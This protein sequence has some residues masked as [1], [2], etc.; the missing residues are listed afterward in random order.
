VKALLI[1]ALCIPAAAWSEEKAQT[2]E[3]VGHLGSRAAL[4]V[5]NATQGP[6]GGWRLTGEYIL[7]PTQTRR[8]LQGERGPELGVTTLKEGSTP[9]LY[10]HDPIGELRGIWRD[11]SFKGTRYAAGGQE[12]EHFEFSEEFPPMHGYSA[13]VR[14][15]AGESTLAYVAEQGRLKSF[16]WR[17]GACTLAGLRQQAAARGGMRLASGG[18]T[19]T[20]REVGELVKVA[21]EGCQ[22]Q[23]RGQ[24][25]PEPLIVERRGSCR[26]LRTQAR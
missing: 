9:I 18:C 12:R 8:F 16:E 14:C 11:G 3:L 1:I 19:V 22:A 5:L 20:L 17:S 23:C 24:A 7:F 6:D 10:G 13:A 4:L 26:L 25:A 21:A 2:S 15:Q